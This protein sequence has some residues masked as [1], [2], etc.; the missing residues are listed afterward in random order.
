MSAR[1]PEAK[2]L[3]RI[4]GPA[5]VRALPEADLPAL[6]QEIR[7]ELIRA[8]SKTGG[9][10]GPNLG[11]VELTIAMHRA[12]ESPKDKI[13][14]DVSHQGYVHKMLTGRREGLDTIRQH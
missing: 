3:P 11:V 12:F 14:F 5:D 4:N 7:D 8:V 2:V 13:L 10:L 1:K 9:H 6:A